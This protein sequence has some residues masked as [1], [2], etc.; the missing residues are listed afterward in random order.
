M[1]GNIE[2][3]SEVVDR[4]TCTANMGLVEYKIYLPI[5]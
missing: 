1:F 4:N 2:N 5:L 3:F